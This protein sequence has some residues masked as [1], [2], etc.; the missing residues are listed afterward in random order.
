M[1]R[2]RALGSCSKQTGKQT[3]TETVQ[4]VDV[5]VG[6]VHVRRP[7]KTTAAK[8]REKVWRIQQ[9]LDHSHDKSSLE[10]IL[11]QIRE[12]H[13]FSYSSSGSGAHLRWV[14]CHRERRVDW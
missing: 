7:R 9:N 10:T 3:S 5:V 4:S 11:L 6:R 8:L 12:F 2:E 1:W 14:E 13:R